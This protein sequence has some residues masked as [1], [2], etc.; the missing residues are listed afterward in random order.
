MQ[1]GAVFSRAKAALN[2]PIARGSITSLAVRSTGIVLL[3]VQAVMA[4]R[5]LGPAGYGVVA[6]VFSIAQIASIG[7]LFGYQSHSVRK[8][9]SD[10]P[11]ARHSEI[12]R[13][14]VRAV[15]VVFSLSM[16]AGLVISIMQF[17]APE[18]FKSNTVTLIHL[19]AL[20]PLLALIQLLKGVNQGLGKIVQSQL[21][22]DLIRPAVLISVLVAL[23]GAGWTLDPESFLSCLVFAYCIALAW[24]IW[25]TIRSIL[26]LDRKQDSGAAREDRS[27]QPHTFFLL[28]LLIVLQSE[29]ATLLLSVL[30]TPEQTGLYQPIARLLPLLALLITA[31]LMPFVPRITELWS[32]GKMSEVIRLTGTFTLATTALSILSAFGLALLAPLVF[33]I[34][35]NDFAAVA[36]LVW[37]VAGAQVFRAMCGPVANLLVMAGHMRQV[38]IGHSAAL[39]TS[40]AVAYFLIPAHGV[41]GAVFA[42]AVNIT[43]WNLVMLFLVRRNLGFDPSIFGAISKLLSKQE[44]P[45]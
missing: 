7:A 38:L 11:H 44:F 20:V 26:S 34:F 41:G 5:L 30:S 27:A 40:V 42:V 24:A 21:P 39:I 25:T 33:L 29:F 10:L 31:A 28:S 16:L 45:A 32:L 35:G 22:H 4:A 12:R 2:G 13:Y 36:P 15:C 19:L 18:I 3:L 9:A 23:I 37:I 1:I 17:A 14:V 8:I 43:V 6:V